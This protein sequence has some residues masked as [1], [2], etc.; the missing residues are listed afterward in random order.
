[1]GGGDGGVASNSNINGGWIGFNIRG[2]GA[3]G[4]EKVACGS[5]VGY[6]EGSAAMGWNI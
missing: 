2:K 1:M 6:I 4:R 5:S 3:F